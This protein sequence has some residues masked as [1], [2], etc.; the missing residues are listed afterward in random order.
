MCVYIYVY[1]SPSNLSRF[2]RPVDVN[3]NSNVIII[4]RVESVSYIGAVATNSI[5][6]FVHRY[7]YYHVIRYVH[8]G[9]IVRR[10]RAVASYV[11]STGRTKEILWR[12]F[13]VSPLNS[14]WRFLRHGRGGGE[15]M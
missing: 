13:E 2:H 15:M 4:V 5:L 7:C 14:L 1:C 3:N 11:R 10:Y 8:Y 12:T 9:A 6:L